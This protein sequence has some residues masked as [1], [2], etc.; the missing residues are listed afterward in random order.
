MSIKIIK[1]GRSDYEDQ[2]HGACVHCG[3][4]F[5]CNKKDGKY[6]G[7]PAMR[8]QEGDYV[9]INCPVCGRGCVAYPVNDSKFD[10]LYE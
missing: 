10:Y 7:R 4:E 9:S 3:A 5:I 1:P 2:F 6:V 8:P